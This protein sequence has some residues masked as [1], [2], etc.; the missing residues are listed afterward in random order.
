MKF[1]QFF[2]VHL[3]HEKYIQQCEDWT[4]KWDKTVEYDSCE[5][6]L[7]S[8]KRSVQTL[9]VSLE[10]E[11][12][13]DKIKDLIEHWFDAAGAE[14]FNIH[15]KFSFFV[16]D[17]LPV[18]S[19]KSVQRSNSHHQCHE[20]SD[21]ESQKQSKLSKKSSSSLK[22]SSRETSS[23]EKSSRS[24]V[25]TQQLAKLWKKRTEKQSLAEQ[26]TAAVASMQK[27]WACQTRK[28]KNYT[29]EAC[30]ISLNEIHI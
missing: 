26:L 22:I 17:L 16:K 30:W 28:C 11:S 27:M 14:F 20:D 24:T 3:L 8:A 10:K 19:A 5:A 15:I 29:K 7:S 21:S 23:A 2:S 1:D 6:V 12:D 18:S 4:V 13:W 25:T 9:S